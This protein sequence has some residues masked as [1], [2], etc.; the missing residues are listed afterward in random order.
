MEGLDPDVVDGRDVDWIQT[1]LL[2]GLEGKSIG[3]ELKGSDPDF[4]D[5]RDVNWKGWKGQRLDP[6]VV[7]G[8]VGRDVD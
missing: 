6:Y 3:R 8:R 4:V 5:E 2:E 1:L 7:A